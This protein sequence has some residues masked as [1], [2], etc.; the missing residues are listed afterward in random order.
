MDSY[1]SEEKKP[2]LLH[3]I[4][5]YKLL[6]NYCAL[7]YHPQCVEINSKGAF[8]LL[9]LRVFTVRIKNHTKATS[10]FSVYK[11]VYQF[12]VYGIEN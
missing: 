6:S 12:L 5:T 10:E 11:K 9:C 7:L 2:T 4:H 3:Y 8:F 1:F